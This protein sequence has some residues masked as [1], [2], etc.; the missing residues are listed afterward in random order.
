MEL[1]RVEDQQGNIIVLTAER[2]NHLLKH[3][4]PRNPQLLRDIVREPHAVVASRTDE[5]ANLY[6][7]EHEDGYVAVVV[8]ENKGF[9]K[10]AYETE[11]VT[12]GDIVWER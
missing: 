6:F 3:R 4:V 9:I 1:F 11:S 12:D 5:N 7:R 10:T 8:D 2:W